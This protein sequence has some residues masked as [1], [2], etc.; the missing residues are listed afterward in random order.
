MKRFLMIFCM[1]IF[2]Q[3]C[4]QNTD[5]NNKFTVYTSFYA[6]QELTE[7]IAGEKA[8]V[9][10]LIPSGV[11]AHDWEPG[12]ADM[13]ALSKADL[14]IYSG[15]DMEP[16]AEKVISGAGNTD[17]IAVEASSGIEPLKNNESTDPHVWLN[18]QNAILELEKIAE[19]LIV[20]DAENAD[21]YREN[22]E[23]AKTEILSLDADFKLAAESF[24]DKEIIVTHG[25]FGYLCEAYGLR[26]YIIEGVAGESEPSSAAVKEVIDRLREKEH[27]VVF[28]VTDG[29]D[30]VARIIAE[31]SG[32]EVFSL[33]TFGSGSGEGYV[34]AMRENLEI[35]KEALNG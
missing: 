2:L 16:W 3:S 31:E 13:V 12:T 32:A 8:E 1:M 30:K 26:Q 25:A 4:T 6:M 5:D 15:M 33:N 17:L 28:Y 34:E 19:G 20:A 24:F 29:S 14:F 9:V 21:Y 10:S 18:P 27:S 23:K 7:M 35:L 22:L 11:D